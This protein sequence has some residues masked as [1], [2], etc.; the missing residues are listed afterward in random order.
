MCKVMILKLMVI[1]RVFTLTVIFNIGIDASA[2]H[3]TKSE[4]E[5]VLIALSELYHMDQFCYLIITN[6]V[7]ETRLLFDQSQPLH[8]I[9]NQMKS[10][11]KIDR[12]I[13]WSSKE[14]QE[15]LSR[16]RMNVRGEYAWKSDV[17]AFITTIKSLIEISLWLLLSVCLIG[18]IWRF[19]LSHKYFFTPQK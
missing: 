17:T 16:F 8:R 13:S 9:A 1:W 18:F 12:R 7:L 5:V 3:F 14:V 2:L 6:N 10:L 4:Q 15:E 11:E 19:L